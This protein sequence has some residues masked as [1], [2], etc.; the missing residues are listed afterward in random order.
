MV[1]LGLEP[2]TAEDEGCKADMNS[3][4]QPVYLVLE[5]HNKP[6]H[7]LALFKRWDGVNLGKVLK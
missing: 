4:R 2:M 7:C 1:H 6:S 3:L 5:S